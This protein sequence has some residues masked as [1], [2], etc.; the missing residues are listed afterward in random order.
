VTPQVDAAVTQ[1][2]A[3]TRPRFFIFSRPMPDVIVIRRERPDHPQVVASPNSFDAC[4]PCLVS[5]YAPEDKHVLGVQALLAPELN[6]LAA[7]RG[8]A[9]VGT[10]A[11]HRLPREAD[12]MLRP[13]GEMK[14]KMLTHAQRGLSL[15]VR[16][17]VA[18]EQTL[19]DSGVRLAL[20]ETGR[21]RTAA[22]RLHERCGYRRRRPFGGYPDN[23]LSP[24]FGKSL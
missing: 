24:F 6:F 12:T 3:A 23:G 18:L 19:L 1:Q 9:V 14:R 16:L 11:A 20:P 22:A 2:G 5:L 10:A 13:S 21:D 4:L 7:W 15:V 17:L 8:D